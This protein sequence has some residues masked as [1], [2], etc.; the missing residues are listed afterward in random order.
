MPFFQVNI[1]DYNPVFKVP[2]LACNGDGYNGVVILIILFIRNDDARPLLE[3]IFIIKRK[4]AQHYFS[5]PKDCPRGH[6]LHCPI[7]LLIQGP[8]QRYCLI[9]MPLSLCPLA[10]LSALLVC[11]VFYQKSPQPASPSPSQQYNAF[12]YIKLYGLIIFI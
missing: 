6:L 5:L 10:Y 12:V 9:L 3:L 2:D 1:I 4:Q 11:A 8:W 7:F